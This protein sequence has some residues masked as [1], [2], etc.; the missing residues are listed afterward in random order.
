MESG[1]AVVQVRSMNPATALAGM[2]CVFALVGLTNTPE[3]AG[4]DQRPGPLA[5][6]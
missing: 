2:K 4:A 5:I 3:L 6:T 1:S